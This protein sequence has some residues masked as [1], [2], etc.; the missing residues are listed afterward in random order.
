[1]GIHAPVEHSSTSSIRWVD[2]GTIYDPR[3][4]SDSK[5]SL[6]LPQKIHC[7]WLKLVNHL[8]RVKTVFKQFNPRGKLNGNENS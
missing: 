5:T 7:E 3:D 1:L 8:N 6:Y 4:I 2:W